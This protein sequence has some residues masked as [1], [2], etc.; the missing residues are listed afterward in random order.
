M[1]ECYIVDSRPIVQLFINDL[2]ESAAEAIALMRDQMTPEDFYSHFTASDVAEFM[3][4]E[5]QVT[6]FFLYIMIISALF[7][8]NCTIM[9]T[10][11]FKLFRSNGLRAEVLVRAMLEKKGS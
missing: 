9:I 8:M 7:T 2:V 6:I 11:A 3:I 1:N 4:H 10:N 5:V